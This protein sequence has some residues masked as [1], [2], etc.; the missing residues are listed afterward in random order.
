MFQFCD[1]SRVAELR[2]HIRRRPRVNADSE[3]NT[4]FDCYTRECDPCYSWDICANTVIDGVRVYLLNMISQ[5]WRSADEVNI[6]LWQHWITI[7]V[8]EEVISD[9]AC[10][11]IEAGERTDQLPGVVSPI[12][13]ETARTTGAVAIILTGVPNQPLV[14]LEGE[15]ARREGAIAA[16]SFHKFLTTGDPSWSVTVPMTKSVIRCMDACQ[17]FLSETPD[18]KT[19]VNRFILSGGSKRGLAAWG[20]A[21]VDKRVAGIV[22]IVSEWVNIGAQMRCQYRIYG[23]VPDTWSDFTEIRLFDL[24]DTEDGKSLLR[25]IDPY[26]FLDRYTMP[27]LVLSASGCPFFLPDSSKFYFQEL[28]GDKYFRSVPNTDHKLGGSDAVFTVMAFFKAIVDGTTLPRH[29]WS[30]ETHGGIRLETPDIP[31]EVLL[32]QATSKTRDFRI[33][34]F[35]PRWTSSP[36]TSSRPGLYQTEPF[37]PGDGWTAHFLELAYDVGLG[38]NCKFTTEVSI[39]H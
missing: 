5:T 15:R 13:V 36:L 25:L 30:I 29:S 3:R 12:L 27:K 2:L 28:P 20:G 37:N 34:T 11:W 16:Y 33:Q 1:K 38:V 10:L 6:P 17:T 7:A 23:H 31:C 35:G 14:F 8:P 9:I 39:T 26:F 4:D 32:W 24:L 22:P 21:T 19:Q 18:I